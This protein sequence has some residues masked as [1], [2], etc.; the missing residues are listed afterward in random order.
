MD[1]ADCLVLRAANGQ[2]DK[3]ERGVIH[4]ISVRVNELAGEMRWVRWGL[5]LALVATGI[6]GGAAATM[7]GG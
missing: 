4:A 5:R 1:K 7:G 6:V 2:L 3:E